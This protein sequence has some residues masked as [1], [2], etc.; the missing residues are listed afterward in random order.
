MQKLCEHIPEAAN[1]ALVLTK[2]SLAGQSVQGYNTYGS[3]D[4]G[5]LLQVFRSV[6]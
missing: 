3:N 2:F 6:Q 4:N 1:D 5:K